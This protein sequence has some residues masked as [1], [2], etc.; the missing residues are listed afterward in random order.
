VFSA[1]SHFPGLGSASQAVEEGPASVSL[2]GA[3]LRRRD[4]VPFRS[5]IDA[6]APGIL[7]ANGLYTYDDFVTPASLS[8][9]VMTGLLRRR[10]GFRGVAITGNLTDPGVTAL[11]QPRAAAVQALKAGADMITIN[12]PASDQEGAYRAVLAAVRTKAI[13]RRRLDEAVGRILS[14]KR[15]YGLVR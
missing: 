7:I 15:D 12:G 8:R 9:S 4:L 10:M 11:F 1:P 13:S 14:V 3:E 5:A 6:G 2:S